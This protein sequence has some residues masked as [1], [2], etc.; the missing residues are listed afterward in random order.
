MSGK[1]ADT[2][3]K[4][5]ADGKNR[6]GWLI[7][8]LGAT[9]GGSCLLSVRPV[10]A[11]PPTPSTAI[12]LA[13]STEPLDM[14][15]LRQG[16]C[17][18]ERRGVTATTISQDKLTVPSLWWTKDQM[19]ATAEFGPKLVDNW[20]ACPGATTGPGRVDFVVNQ[21]LWSLL[22][23]LERYEFVNRF[24]LV[25]RSYG[26]NIRVFNRQ[27]VLVAAYTCDFSPTTA[28]AQQ[29]QIEAADS[30]TCAMLLDSSGKAGFR[31]RS[32]NSLGASL[33]SENDRP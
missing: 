4:P 31:G 32:T 17:S 30:L 8:L 19:A 1:I 33:P 16:W 15:R 24:G 2:R 11:N 26:Y 10:Q 22:D 12:A 21:Q 25:A 7:L 27:A 14:R 20:L 3:S 5:G 18:Q 29:K 6:L 23:Y 9:T 28:M 13:P